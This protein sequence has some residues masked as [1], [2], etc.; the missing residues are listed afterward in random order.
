MVLRTSE[1]LQSLFEGS[2]DGIVIADERGII[3][4]ANS[5]CLELL[6]YAPRELEGQPI[7]LLV[8]PR[9][10]S[11]PALRSAYQQR[12]RPRA[13]GTGLDLTARHRDGREIPVDVSLTPLALADRTWVAATLRDLRRRAATGETLRVQ[14]TALRSAANG[15]IITD[16]EGVIS[17][18]N[19]AACRITGYSEQELLGQH[20]RALKSGKHEPQFYAQLWQTVLGGQAWSGTIVNRRKD[21]TLY[22]EEQTIAPVADEAGNISHFIA[23][24]QDVTERRLA[25]AA[26]AAVRADLAARVAEIESLNAQLREQAVRDPLTGLYNRRYFYETIEREVSAS[27]RSALP[28]SLLAIDVDHFKQVNDAHGHAVGD[29]ALLALAKVIGA[30]IRAADMACRFGGEEFV[31]AMPGATLEVAERRAEDLRGRF[32]ATPIA[33]PARQPLRVTVSIGVAAMRV[34]SEAV[35]DALA[36]ADAALYEAKLAG[37]N[38][39]VAHLEATSRG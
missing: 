39:V 19:P 29:A 25:E 37:R 23:I 3:Q 38:R 2:P 35:S 1:L 18:V 7:E 10:D 5:A 31:I 9:V 36:R 32:S 27:R 34:D 26:L 24:K 22:D 33:T 11:H 15:V 4:Q 12:P 17:W 28:L 13:M 16:R 8:P 6:G 30:C 14:A 21:G 20:T